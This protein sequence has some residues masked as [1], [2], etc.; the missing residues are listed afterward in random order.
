M[1][2]IF[3]AVDR[4]PECI[5]STQRS[6]FFH[7]N[8]GKKGVAEDAIGQ[9]LISMAGRRTKLAYQAGIKKAKQCQQETRLDF[10]QESRRLPG[11]PRFHSGIVKPTMERLWQEIGLPAQERLRRNWSKNGAK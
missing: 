7:T 10:P 8:Y 3:P 2:L 6:A 4:E 9:A 1:T 5:P 11:T